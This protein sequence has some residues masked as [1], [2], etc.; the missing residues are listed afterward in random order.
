VIIAA[1]IGFKL[2]ENG[3]QGQDSRP[4]RIQQVAEESL[5]RLRVDAIDIFNQHRPDPNV[6]VEYVAGTVKDLFQ[7][8]KSNIS[9]CPNPQR[10]IRRAHTGQ[11]VTALQSEY[12]IPGSRKLAHLDD[13]LGPLD[14]ELTADDLSAIKAAM[15]NISVV[16][17]RY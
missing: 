16:G 2:D 9:G 8:G 11:P 3:V 1:K 4:E 14:L 12:S 15:A 7:E 13:N 10:P 5:K 6:P 17:D